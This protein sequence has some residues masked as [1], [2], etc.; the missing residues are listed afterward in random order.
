MDDKLYSQIILGIGRPGKI[1]GQVR[2]TIKE[3]FQHNKCEYQYT[4]W[5]KGETLDAAGPRRHQAEQQGNRTRKK[6]ARPD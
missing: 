6:D 5:I 4:E 3:I 2:E 1:Y